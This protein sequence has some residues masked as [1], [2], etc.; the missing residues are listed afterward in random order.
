MVEPA[1]PCDCLPYRNICSRGP[2][3]GI[4]VTQPACQSLPDGSVVNNPAFVGP[5]VNKSYWTYK[6]LIDAGEETE[7]IGKIAIVICETIKIT[8][9]VVSEKV[10]ECG[11]FIPVPFTLTHSDPNFGTAPHG[12]QLLVVHNNDRYDTGVSVAYRLEISGDFATAVEP[13]K[14]RA[15]FCVLIYDCGCF[16]I[17]KCQDQGQ[18]AVSKDCER[19]IIDNRLLLNYS[20]V[21]SNIGNASLSDVDFL[22]EI[23]IPLQF[24]L[25][26]ITVDP[27]SLAVDTE[28]PGLIKISGSLGT[29]DPGEKQHIEYQIQ[30]VSISGPGEYVVA[31]TASATSGGVQASASCHLKVDAVELSVNKCCSLNNTSGEFALKLSAIELSPATLLDIRDSMEIPAGITLQFHSFDG[32]LATFEDSGDPV[33]LDTDIPGPAAINIR[34]SE[35]SVPAAGMTQRHITFTVVCISDLRTLELVNIIQQV[36]PSDPGKQIFLGAHPVPAEAKITL[37]A[38]ATCS[39]PC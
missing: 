24:T 10:D 14:V 38:S 27:P 31:N 1:H 5:P 34:C 2:K 37:F 39:N 4:S 15:G 19:A 28:T 29:M 36:T 32:C 3:N 12:F 33:P 8:D 11:R 35:V 22:D 6:F 13:I 20:V 16:I 9:L 7:P 25:G 30:V 21:V 17:P 23:E 18:L 26:V